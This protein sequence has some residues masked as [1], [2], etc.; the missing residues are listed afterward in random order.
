MRQSFEQLIGLKWLDQILGTTG[1]H[2]GYDLVRAGVA[3]RCEQGYAGF[4]ALPQLAGDL[5]TFLAF[6]KIDDADPMLKLLQHPHDFS[7]SHQPINVVDYVRARR[8]RYQSFQAVAR[9]RIETDA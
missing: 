9:S 5:G 3:R 4:T 8:L 6:V 7:R 1:A 2:G